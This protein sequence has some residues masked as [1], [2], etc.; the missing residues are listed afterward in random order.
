MYNRP[1]APIF[2]A[3]IKLRGIFT[4]QLKRLAAEGK[5]DND[6]ASLPDLGGLPPVEESM[7]QGA[8]S[9]DDDDDDDDE[10]GDED[11]DD[12]D[13][14]EDYEG[15]S[16]DE[17]RRRHGRQ[18]SHDE[19]DRSK[20][21]GRPPLVLTP[22]EARITAILRGLKN[23]KNADSVVLIEP[24]EKLPDRASIPDYYQTITNPIAIDSVKK[25]MKRKKYRSVEQAMSDIDLMFEN[26]K[27]YNEDDSK[28]HQAAVEL[29]TL[30][31][32]LA[33]EQLAKPDDDFRDEDGKLPLDEFSE[34]GETWHVGK[35]S[36]H[37]SIGGD[38]NQYVQVTGFI[39]ATPMT[40]Q[41]QLWLKYI[42]FGRIAKAHAGSTLA[43]TIDLSKPSTGL[44]NTSMSMKSSKPAS[45][46]TIRLAK[47][48]IAALSCSSHDLTREGRV[49][50][51][52][53]SRYM[54]ASRVTTKKTPSSIRS[55]HGR[56]AS[57]T[58][59]EIEITKWICTMSLVL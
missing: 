55:R 48:W 35:C 6:E 45:I 21:R 31:H 58:R 37:S 9:E 29:Q 10:D 49:G 33:A 14:E 53:R 24:F 38:A 46:G 15:D 40:L 20:K 59:F 47:L 2:G 30:A 5:I 52:P 54:F 25:N 11:D 34:G 22:V 56:A 12:D 50:S 32:M 41:S 36:T 4:E 27:T 57:Q 26:A 8:D 17:R 28:L 7:S 13:D 23:F 39:F 44:T 42:E 3:A 51:P 16:G 1:S 43:G 18:T 19:E